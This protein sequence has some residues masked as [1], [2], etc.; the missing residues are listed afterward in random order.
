MAKCQIYARIPPRGVPN[1]K[2]PRRNGG[3]GNFYKWLPCG[4]SGGLF[5]G[6]RFS[7]PRV[8]KCEHTRGLATFACPQVLARSGAQWEGIR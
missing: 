2:F 5:S 7:R 4:E 1:M 8:A 3:E 6:E